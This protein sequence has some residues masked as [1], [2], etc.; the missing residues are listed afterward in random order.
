M[1][2]DQY[3]SQQY[4][5]SRAYAQKTIKDSNV[6]INGIVIKKT[7]YI[8]KSKDSVTVN[9]APIVKLEVE[10]ESIPLD[11]VI[12]DKE[13]LVINKPSGMVVHPACGHY[14]GTLVNALLSYCKKDLSG[15]AGVAR[16]GIVHRLD[17][18]TTGLIIVAKTDIA[19]KNL[20]QQFKNRLI[21]KKYRALVNGNIKSEQGTINQPL[22]CNPKNRKKVIVTD[23]PKYKSKE[24][25]THFQVLKRFQSTT[26]L[27]VRIETG[28]THQIR[29]HLAFIGHPIVGDIIYGKNKKGALRLQAYYLSF[30]HPVSDKVVEVEI[31][32]VF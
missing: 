24:A 10:A 15:I 9:I 6:L 21:T 5:I 18:D 19:H 1:R 2:L 4:G 22:G 13:F 12:E 11:V 29:V 26:L 17:K 31:P 8:V 16:P 30:K 27:D 3:I 32:A 14:S 28:R 25:I 7:A 20:S 23:D